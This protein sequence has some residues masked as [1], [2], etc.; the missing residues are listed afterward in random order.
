MKTDL[1][2]LLT[3]NEGTSLEF[4]RTIDSPGRIAKT[5]AAFANTAGG[6]L[7]VGIDDDHSV[8]GV[9]SEKDEI[10]RLE[11][12]S[13]FWVEPPLLLHYE[14]VDVGERRVLIFR[15]DESREKPHKAKNERGE[16]E[17]YVRARDKSVPAS[18]Q[19]GQFLQHSGAVDAELLNSPNVKTL[20]QFLQKSERITAPRLA[21]LINIS[22]YRAD[23]LL[24]EL[25]RQGALLLLENQSPKSYVLRK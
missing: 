16:W 17:I 5:L 8:R 9:P 18:K 7:V 22:T 19:M 12:A 15:V 14:T 3:Q 23:R 13:D 21:K 11:T 4:K 2:A 6:L 1:A 10:Q 25:T 24:R 20:F